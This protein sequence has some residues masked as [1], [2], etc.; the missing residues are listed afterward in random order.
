M[1]KVCPSTGKDCE[2]TGC[3]PIGN[4]C[5]LSMSKEYEILSSLGA[6]MLQ[7]IDI[8]ER[9]K[10]FF[11]SDGNR[12]MVS[13]CDS[14]IITYKKVIIK[15]GELTK[16]KLKLMDKEKEELIEIIK[17]II[18]ILRKHEY[19]GTVL[20]IE[21]FLNIYMSKE[22]SKPDTVSA[23]VEQLTKLGFVV[24]C[25]EDHTSNQDLES[26]LSQAK[27]LL[28]KYRGFMQRNVPSV[29]SRL[30]LAWLEQRDEIESFL[31]S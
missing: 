6:W 18:P 17:T 4:E 11:K 5:S 8:T 7:E 22:E 14:S 30:W 2:Y 15:I 23:M 29:Q 21:S 20:E 13:R 1:S 26:Q 19:Y 31:K 10:K 24:L 28:N 25:P 12:N 3:N 27:E 16:I 9:Q